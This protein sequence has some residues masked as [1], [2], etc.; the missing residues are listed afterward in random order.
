MKRVVD[1][2]VVNGINVFVPHAF[3]MTYPDAD[4]PPRR[5]EAAVAKVEYL[6]AFATDPIVYRIRAIHHTTDPSV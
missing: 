1:H 6:S 2:M 4:C 3:S 5:V